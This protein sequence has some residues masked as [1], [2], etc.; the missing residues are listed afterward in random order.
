MGF[1]KRQT[2]QVLEKNSTTTGFPPFTKALNSSIE[3]RELGR[4]LRRK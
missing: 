4:F 3:L 2:L 1:E